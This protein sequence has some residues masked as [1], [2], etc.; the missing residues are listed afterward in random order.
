M[1]ISNFRGNDKN[2]GFTLMELLIV[3][4]IMAVLAAAIA[5]SSYGSMIKRSRV[6][7]GVDTIIS[8]LRTV[9]AQVVD[10]YREEVTPGVFEPKCL[11]VEIDSIVGEVRVVKLDYLVS[12]R[13]CDYS[14]P[15]VEVESV[16][17]PIGV[18]V[19]EIEV[20]SNVGME[21]VDGLKV[22]FEPPQAGFSLVKTGEMSPIDEDGSVKA[23]IK[24][25]YG[26]N[27]NVEKEFTLDQVT[28]R[29]E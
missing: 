1:V 2:A 18:K 24:V 16:G 29:M 10:G 17:L 14:Q 15:V 20:E 3:I 5:A 4:T 11:G 6:E 7:I 9:R 19:G 21:Q 26:D 13:K 27:I 22:I 8:R 25:R 23:R 28:G 12:Q